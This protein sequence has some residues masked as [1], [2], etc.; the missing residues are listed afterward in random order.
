MVRE[1]I[2]DPATGRATGVH[3]IDK[4]TRQDCRAKARVVILAASG[5][6]SARILLNSKSN[7]FAQGLGNGSGKI[8]RYL[9]DT[10][11]AKVVGQIPAMEK[12]PPHNE[13]GD[14]GLHMYVPWWGYQAQKAGKLDFPRGY[15]IEFSG[16]RR[17]PTAQTFTGLETLTGGSYGAKFKEDARR[18]YGS[19][20][21]FGG[22]GEMIP[23]EDCY[24]E[25]DPKVVDQWG[26]PVLR[27]HW[28]WAEPELRQASHMHRTFKT[29]IEQMG[30]R[31][32]STCYDGSD[33]LAEGAKAI[34]RPGE[35]I[36]EVGT[37]CMGAEAQSSVLNQWC[38][39]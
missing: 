19:F 39:S 32:M 14:S 20:I 29:L 33:H 2:Y 21:S 28:K 11:G 6:E 38:Q 18:Y 5:C 26:I 8:G 25:L 37:T 13:D 17:A 23:N 3:Y 36:H 34:Y 24:C 35:I 7:K 10:V 30:G 12:T 4:K 9:M 1:V 15:H 27:F 22:R 31:V 16:G